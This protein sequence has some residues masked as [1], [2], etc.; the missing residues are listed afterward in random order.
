MFRFCVYLVI[1]GFIFGFFELVIYGL[2][3]EKNFIDIVVYI[4]VSSDRELYSFRSVFCCCCF[5]LV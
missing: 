1:V 5:V 2:G 3:V 4:G